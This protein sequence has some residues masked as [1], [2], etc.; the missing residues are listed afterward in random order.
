M[1]YEE[2]TSGRGLGLGITCSIDMGIKNK[3]VLYVLSTYSFNY[4]F[5]LKVSP[6]PA[7]LYVVNIL[8]WNKTAVVAAI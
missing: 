4:T 7:L 5:K 2:L 1:D 3:D 6:F 8:N